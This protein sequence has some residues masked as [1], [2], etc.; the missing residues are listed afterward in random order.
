MK[1]LFLILAILFL[2]ATA[3]SQASK[4]QTAKSQPL[5]EWFRVY[6]YDD[7]IIELNTNYVMFSN[8]KI[9]RVRFRWSFQTPQP[10][11]EKSDV[12]YQSILQEV[13]FDCKHKTFRLYAM[14]W[15]DGEGKVVASEKKKETKELQE[16]QSGSMIE[17]LFPQA[18]KLIELRK[19]EPAVEQ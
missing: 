1:I 2:Q 17:K 19:R 3:K 10:L 14:Q 9:E 13:Q 6:T 4:Y 16:I 15:F 18:C 7:S 5:P 11:S 12:K 8:Y